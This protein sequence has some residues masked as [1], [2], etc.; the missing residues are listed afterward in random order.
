MTRRQLLRAAVAAAGAPYVITSAALGGPQR[1]VASDRI[2][3][4]FIGVGG[5]GSHDL[6]VF[7][8]FKEVQV[9]CVCDVFS[10]RRERARSAVDRKYGRGACKAYADFRELLARQDIDAVCIASPEHWHAAHCI[11]AARQ[12]KDI[13]CE[14]PLALTPAEA[15]E[16]ANAV[17]RYDRVFQVGTQQRSDRR[18][19]LACELVRNG[20]LGK[21]LSAHVD[22]GGPSGP[23]DLPP[24]PVPRGLDWDTWL[25]P[26]P[27]APYNRKRCWNLMEW[28]NWRDYSGGQMTD[29]GAHDFDVVQ[30]ALGMDKSG[31]VEVVPPDGKA[32]KGVM[33]RYADGVV[34]QSGDRDDPGHTWRARVTFTGTDGEAEVWRWQLRTNPP[35]LAQVR[36][37]PTEVHLYRSD[38]HAGNFLGC[39]RTRRPCVAD[40]EAGCRSVTVCHLGNIAYWLNRPIRWDPTAE[41]IIGDDEANRMLARPRRQPWS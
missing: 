7:M 17:R 24:E 30:W 23:C 13:Y 27:W 22:T 26:A 20:Y 15:R 12:G 10:D 9:A 5:R 11:E 19:R 36:L 37:G 29:R 39:I 31:P 6:G 38:N 3:M 40:V 18:F 21:L 4:G 33:F 32:R 41:Q 1:P 14:K 8:G 35:S 28:W 2:T 25:G 16:A 34:L